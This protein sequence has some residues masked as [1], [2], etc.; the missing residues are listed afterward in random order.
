MEPEP[1]LDEHPRGTIALVTLL[2]LF[3]VV[4]WLAVYVFIF[5]ARGAPHS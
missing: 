1:P 3:F 4:G 2:G 5:L